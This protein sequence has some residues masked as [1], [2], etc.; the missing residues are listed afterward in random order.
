MDTVRGFAAQGG[1][2]AVILVQK[3]EIDG[4]ATPEKDA[5]LRQ[6]SSMD[7]VSAKR[8]LTGAELYAEMSCYALAHSDGVN[9]TADTAFAEVVDTGSPTEL[10]QAIARTLLN[11]VVHRYV[12]RVCA[13]RIWQKYAPDVRRNACVHAVI[14]RIRLYTCAN[15]MRRCMA[16]WSACIGSRLSC[17]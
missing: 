11:F 6:E 17:I 12:C 2:D 15:K 4:K 7:D 10:V 9:A 5:S 3:H 14:L 13:L 16:G 8:R 1:M